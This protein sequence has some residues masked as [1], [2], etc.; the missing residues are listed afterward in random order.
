VRR[1]LPAPRALRRE[2][3]E[4]GLQRVLRQFERGDAVRAQPVEAVRVFEHRGVAARFHVGEDL[5]DRLLDR[6][7]LA[8][9]EG[10]QRTARRRSRRASNRVC[11]W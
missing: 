6:F 11:G 5:R 3:V 9:L 2:A 7:V 4:R 1:R 8:R 10:E